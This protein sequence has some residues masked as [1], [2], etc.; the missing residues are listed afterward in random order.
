M[1]FIAERR[2]HTEDLPT[3]RCG[4]ARGN[5]ATDNVKKHAW[6]GHTILIFV[7]NNVDKIQAK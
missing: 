5:Y 6:Q 1:P 4:G 3:T 2:T 7:R